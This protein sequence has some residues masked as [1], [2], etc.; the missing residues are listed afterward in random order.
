MEFSDTLDGRGGDSAK[1]AETFLPLIPTTPRKAKMT[2]IWGNFFIFLSFPTPPKIENCQTNKTNFL[3][4]RPSRTACGFA[5][6]ERRFFLI[7][8]C[9][10]QYWQFLKMPKMSAKKQ[11]IFFL[12]SCL[13]V[14]L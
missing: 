2:E 11:E 14:P 8:L 3:F 1:A 9:A 12:I 5:K 4:A 6:R 10:A 13:G 7:P